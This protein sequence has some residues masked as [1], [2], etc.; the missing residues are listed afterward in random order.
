VTT[1]ILAYNALSMI[2][3]PGFFV[4][5]EHKIVADLSG[6]VEE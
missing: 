1:P 5:A 4:F 3:S 2:P 6:A